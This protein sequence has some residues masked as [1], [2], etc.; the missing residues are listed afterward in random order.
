MRGEA[1]VGEGRQ[2]NI[3]C[4]YHS[5]VRIQDRC[6]YYNV[7]CTRVYRI[8]NWVFA[9]PSLLQTGLFLLL[10][11]VAQGQCE[12]RS[13][14]ATVSYIAGRARRSRGHSR[15]FWVSYLSYESEHRPTR[16][17]TMVAI[18]KTLP[19]STSATSTI[20]TGVCVRHYHWDGFACLVSI[21]KESPAVI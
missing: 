12:S 3:R 6:M 14:W 11:A 4:Y 5:S 15:Y 10:C 20:V 8:L 21:P 18:N 17:E 19:Y 13:R 2:V 1:P 7:Y 9:I 16:G